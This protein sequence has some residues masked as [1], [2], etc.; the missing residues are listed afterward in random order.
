MWTR[1]PSS[2]PSWNSRAP[3]S[4]E[5]TTAAAR[6]WPG[7][8]RGGGARLVVVLDEAQQPL[9][10]GRVAGQVAAHGVGALVD[11]PVVEALVVAVVEA[12][13]LERPLHVPV[14]LGDEHEVRAARLDAADHVRPEVLGRAASRARPRC[15]RTPR[16]SSASPCRSAA[17][18]HCAPSPVSSSATASR[19]SGEN[20]LSCTTSGHGGK[21]GSRPRATI[22]AGRA[23]E[24]GGVARQVVL[25]AGARSS[26]GARR[27]TDGRARRGWGRSRGSARARARRAAARASA[28]ASGPPKR[29]STTYSRTQY[30]EPITSSGS[31]SGSAARKPAISPGS[32]SAIASPAGRAPP[33]AH[34][35]D[36]VDRQRRERVPRPR[37]AR[38][39]ACRPPS[40]TA[41]LIS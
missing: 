23:Q 36:G 31:R 17:P 35:P 14:G 19:S 32:S 26:P 3:G 25:G 12:L 22:A 7:A 15:G 16:W 29:S 18:S 8:E 5:A 34:Q 2:W 27:A 4:V 24:R 20:A 21:Y 30:G 11:Q 40:Q 37:R 28:S 39:P 1:C 6:A 33:H 13:L 38:R 41:V 9:L 10:V